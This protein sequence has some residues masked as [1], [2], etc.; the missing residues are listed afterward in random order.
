MNSTFKWSLLREAN[1]VP[2][3]TFHFPDTVVVRGLYLNVRR[4][5]TPKLSGTDLLREDFKGMRHVYQIKDGVCINETSFCFAHVDAGHWTAHNSVETGH[6]FLFFL[7]SICT[8]SSTPPP[9]KN[10]QKNIWNSWKWLWCTN[11]VFA[12]HM[13][14]VDTGKKSNKV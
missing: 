14:Y 6:A 13:Y 5:F 8:P 10:K 12:M 3:P 11:D 7:S 9:K 2:F 1:N 4:F